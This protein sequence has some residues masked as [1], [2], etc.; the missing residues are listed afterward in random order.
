MTPFDNVGKRKALAGLNS[1]DPHQDEF[2][3]GLYSASCTGRTYS[4]LLRCA[5]MH[6]AGGQ[7]VVIDASW[8][9]PSLRERA[10]MLASSTF[11]RV[12]ELEC[13]A[14][15]EVSIERIAHRPHGASDATRSV[16]DS[17]AGR[18]APWPRA[19][20]LD[21]TEPATCTTT[22]AHAALHSLI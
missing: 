13:T 6:L 2:E 11:S 21:T 20:R 8:P 16:Y 18:R 12:V 14:P 4:E 9:D 22:R 5:Q 17:M 7:S 19:T 15:A 3:H 1:L 10:A